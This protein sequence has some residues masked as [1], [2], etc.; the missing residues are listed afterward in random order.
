MTTGPDWSTAP[1]WANFVA[2]DDDG[3][4]FWFEHEPTFKFGTQWQA[5]G[6]QVLA[7]QRASGARDSL[8]SRPNPG[9]TCP[10]H[11]PES[12]T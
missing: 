6:R 2:M 4:W 12:A 10:S 3:W 1:K 8:Q 9:G 5:T 7:F 11:P